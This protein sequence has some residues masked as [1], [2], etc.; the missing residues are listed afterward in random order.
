MCCLGAARRAKKVTRG[1]Q[2]K[3]RWRVERMCRKRGRQHGWHPEE[4]E[5]YFQQL[6][7]WSNSGVN[8]SIRERQLD[9][10]M[11][12]KPYRLDMKWCTYLEMLRNANTH[13]TLRNGADYEELL[14]HYLPSRTDLLLAA[15]RSFTLTKV[16]ARRTLLKMS[17]VLV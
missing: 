13:F 8:V 4:G 2:K 7:N 12:T 3:P 1:D 16:R 5:P 15:L 14:F 17:Q 9:R 11:K 6:L 10:T